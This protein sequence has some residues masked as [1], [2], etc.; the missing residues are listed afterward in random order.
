MHYL[1]AVLLLSGWLMPL[2]FLPW[3]SWHSEVLAF[4]SVF[5]AAWMGLGRCF[6]HNQ[7]CG[8]ALPLLTW[9]FFALALLAFLQGAIGLISFGGDALVLAFYA[10]LCI[11]CLALGFAS[12]QQSEAPRP[13]ASDGRREVQALT[14][15][16]VVLT[17]GACVSALLALTQVLELYE[18]SSWINQMPDLRRPGGNMGQ[19]NHLATLVLMGMASL[20][21]LYESR[22][23]TA[24]PSLF[25]CFVLCVGVAITESRSG[26]L[27]FVLMLVWWLLKKR[28]VGFRLS[29]LVVALTAVGLLATSWAWP[30]LFGLIKQSVAVGSTMHINT[31]AG[32]RLL[33]W[34][35]LLE[36]LMLRPWWGWGLGEV[37][38]AHNA[39]AHSYVVSEPFSY[40]H[41]ILLDVALGI[42]IPLTVLA[43]LVAAVWLWR[44]VQGVNQLVPWYCLA[45]C[46]PVA[47]QSMLE[48]PFAYAYFLAP[49]MFALGALEGMAGVRPMLHIGRRAAAVLL[50]GATAMV[51]WSIVEYLMIEEDFRVA[52]FEALRVGQTPAEY[53]RPNVFV[54]TQL[55]A[56]L[57]GARIV[58]KPGM[59]ADE[60][61]L[62]K[63]VALRYPWTATQNRYA[64][65]LALNGRTEEAMRQLAV[66]RAMYGEKKFAPIRA[67]WVSLGQDKYPQLRD[68]PLP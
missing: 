23:L 12:V 6:R 18:H 19:P 14:C 56:L 39:V 48:Y 55:N 34:P 57:G 2:H 38:K 28:S 52:R 27:S 20:L 26:L 60:L 62:A 13:D 31:A 53:A 30:F 10:A 41:N 11:V 54:L 9:P 33:V 16:A 4:F 17:I 50:L 42:G 24:L 40:S 45:V 22:K 51:A 61:T 3:V 37:P 35:Q 32:T 36:A 43:V 25:I 68:L 59:T 44:R 1:P 65:S 67:N 7:S 66:M 21:L 8:V 5:F 29:P 64:L 15:L 46:L 47:V 58:P 49:V 63:K